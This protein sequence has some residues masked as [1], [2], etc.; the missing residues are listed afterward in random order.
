MAKRIVKVRVSDGVYRRLEALAREF[1][2]GSVAEAARYVLTDYFAR[3]LQAGQETRNQDSESAN[4][5]IK[6]EV[7]LWKSDGLKSG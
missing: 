3:G 7:L 2:G 6:L 4:Q 1:F 5:P